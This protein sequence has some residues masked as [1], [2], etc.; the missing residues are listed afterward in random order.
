MNINI[1]PI[2]NNDSEA[3]I[4]IILPIQQNEFNIA[5]G[6]KDQQDLLTIEE[7]YHQGGGHFWGAKIDGELVGTIGLIKC[8]DDFGA[9]RKMFVKKEYRGKAYGIAQ[10]LLETL[11]A[12]SKEIGLKSL[13]LG[14]KDVLQAALRFYEK[15]GFSLIEKGELPKAFPMMPVDNVF[16]RL[17]L[18]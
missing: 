10:L 5:I 18:Q 2:Y 9:I 14:T 15:N 12:Y 4:N 11:V 1:V 3:V 17:S 8:N 7:F 6:I 16:C 13:Y